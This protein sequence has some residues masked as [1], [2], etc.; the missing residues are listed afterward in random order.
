MTVVEPKGFSRFAKRHFLSKIELALAP[1]CKYNTLELVEPL[2]STAEARLFTHGG[3]RRHAEKTNDQTPASSTLLYHL[4]KHPNPEALLSNL[5]KLIDVSLELSLRSRYG[6]R[7]FDVAID[8]TPTPYYGDPN[9]P[10]VSTTKPDRGTTYG[11][12]FAVASIIEPGFRPIVAVVFKKPRET[13]LDIIRRLIVM[14]EHRGVRIRILLLDRAFY[15]GDV[16]NLLKRKRI[17]FLMPARQNARAGRITALSPAGTVIKFRLGTAEHTLIIASYHADEKRPFATNIP[18]GRE[19]AQVLIQTYRK[20]W[21]IETC[22]RQIHDRRPRTT[23]RDPTVR[24]F[25]FYLSALVFNL[26]LLL[27]LRTP[28]TLGYETPIVA[29]VELLALLSA[30]IRDCG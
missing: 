27:N 4:H 16:I 12:V 28:Y 7:A 3:F 2:L 5:Q 25:Y 15:S 23:S 30:P 18:V 26:W 24:A 6:R 29:V 22:F 9:F 13:C 14:I 19:D 21:G 8:L 11:Y 1:N 20:R 17:H 10:M